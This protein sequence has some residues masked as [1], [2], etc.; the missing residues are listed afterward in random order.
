MVKKRLHKVKE[1]FLND[2]GVVFTL[3]RSGASSQLCGWIDMIVSFVL[4]AFCNMTP[5]MSTATGAFV[6]GVFNCII[7]YRFTFHA[8]DVAWRAVITKFLFVWVGSL[9]LNSFGT[10]ILYYLVRDWSWLTHT[11]GLGD[12]SIFLAARLLVSLVVSLAWNFLLQRNFVYRQ[13][14]IDEH[15]LRALDAIGIKERKYGNTD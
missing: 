3:L 6:G 15:I 11:I 4:F 10:Q 7:N 14:R 2:N 5:W 1:Q 8:R 9:L 12:D 13:T